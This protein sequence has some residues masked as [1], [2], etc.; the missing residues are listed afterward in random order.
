MKKI[1]LFIILGLM[2]PP[3][4]TARITCSQFKNY[5]DAKNYLDAKKPGYKSLDRNRDGILYYPRKTKQHFL[6]R[7]SKRAKI[8]IEKERIIS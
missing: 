3:P 5:H 4:I 8:T 1:S 2:L 7:Y 6:N